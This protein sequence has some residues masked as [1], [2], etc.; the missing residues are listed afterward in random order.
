[1]ASQ[2]D[3]IAY[4]YYSSSLEAVD[5][6]KDSRASDFYVT[7]NRDFRLPQGCTS[8]LSLNSVTLPKEMLLDRA[9]ENRNRQV[10]ELRIGYNY[11]TT[12]MG[13]ITHLSLM[14]RL[15]N[16]LTGDFSQC[17]PSTQRFFKQI[18]SE[19]LSGWAQTD[20]EEAKRS[21]GLSPRAQAERKA[22]IENLKS[23][24]EPH[25]IAGWRSFFF[26]TSIQ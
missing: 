19:Y 4:T 15:L 23:M 12:R 20:E 17:H 14:S 6:Q 1:M 21:Q 22:I 18:A 9:G 16:N 2:L 13:F 11:T 5:G 10:V 3:R 7:L 26:K 8:G 25:E 24:T